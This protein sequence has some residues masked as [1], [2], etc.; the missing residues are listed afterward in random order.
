[1]KTLAAEPNHVGSAH[2]KPNAEMKIETFKVLAP[3]LRPRP[4]AG[5]DRAARA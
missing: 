2:D 5:G 1:M 4:P 3:P